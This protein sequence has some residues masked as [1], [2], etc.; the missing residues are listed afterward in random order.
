MSECSIQ[1]KL[2]IE[3]KTKN[4]AA[5]NKQIKQLQKKAQK[6]IAQKTIDFDKNGIVKIFYHIL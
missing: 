5:L 3:R 6:I 4:I 1:I 2:E